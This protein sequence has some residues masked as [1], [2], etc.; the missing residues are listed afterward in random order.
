MNINREIHN[1]PLE[2]CPH[3]IVLKC[4]YTGVERCVNDA[5]R[6]FDITYSSPYCI[7]EFHIEGKLNGLLRISTLLGG[8][9]DEYVVQFHRYG[10][11]GFMM[12]EIMFRILNCYNCYENESDDEIHKLYIEKKTDLYYFASGLN[13]IENV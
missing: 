10:G 2:R 13:N 4:S 8:A 3:S 6:R 5:L 11:D 7:S 9:P 1:K 12:Y